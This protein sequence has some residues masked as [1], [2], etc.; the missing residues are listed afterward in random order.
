MQ[1]KIVCKRELAPKTILFEIE[2][3][4]IAERGRAGQFIILRTSEEGERI[5][6][7]IANRNPEL[8][9]ITIV[10]QEVGKTT[11]DLNALNEGDGILDLAGPLGRATDI[12]EGGKTVVCV[13]GGIGNAVVWPQ[14]S[15][16]KAAGNEVIAILGARNKE[17]LILEEEIAAECDELIIT[18]D[19]GSYGR[20]GLVT[21]ALEDLIQ[22]GKK[23]DEVITIGPVIMM[24]FVCKTTNPYGIPTQ[25]SLNP[26]MVDGTGM[27]GACRVTV[28]GDTRFA[29]VEGPEFDGH[30]VD[31]DELMVRLAYYKEEEGESLEHACKC[32][33][34]EA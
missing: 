18:T 30:K 32:E 25:A 12:P 19:D 26:I 21:N 34:L 14:V 16:L 24:K 1:N 27:C 23:I 28:D 33:K 9:T 2:A 31:F 22:G 8:G 13:G 29:C 15:A 20:E 10:A 4:H 3:P 17:L 7:T 11:R 6:L 5:P